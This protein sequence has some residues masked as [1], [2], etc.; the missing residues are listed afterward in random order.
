MNEKGI[1]A[2]G[3]LGVTERREW[4]WGG[5]RQAPV[6]RCVNAEGV[7]FWGEKNLSFFG[8]VESV[9]LPLDPP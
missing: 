3:A 1:N 6:A 8:G 7:R 4:R 2:K 5:G 9:V